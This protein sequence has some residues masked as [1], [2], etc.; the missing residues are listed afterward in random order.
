MLLLMWLLDF[1]LIIDKV[2]PLRH[3]R[4]MKLQ[5]GKGGEYL[6]LVTIAANNKLHLELELSPETEKHDSRF[7]KGILVE[8]HYAVILC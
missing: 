5:F 4:R 1:Y 8:S 3:P 7:I 2:D 6:L